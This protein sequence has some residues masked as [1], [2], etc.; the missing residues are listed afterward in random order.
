MTEA[1]Y[2]YNKAEDEYDSGNF[3]GAAADYAA[4]VTTQEKAIKADACA[5][6][7]NQSAQTLEGTG[8]MKGI[9]YLIAGIGILVLGLSAGIGIIAWGLRKR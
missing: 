2:L 1:W 3:V 6:L 5:A 4:A 7:T 9:G 8:G